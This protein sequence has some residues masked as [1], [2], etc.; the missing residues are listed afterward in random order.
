MST[1]LDTIKGLAKESLMPD[2]F[3]ARVDEE[4]LWGTLRQLL[5][6]IAAP[7]ATITR[8][9]GLAAQ[10]QTA[11][12]FIDKVKAANLWLQVKELV[13]RVQVK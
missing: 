11:T 12:E 7:G 8:L 10:S 4:G 2:F 9:K 13:Q 5:T 1:D 3:G 6:G